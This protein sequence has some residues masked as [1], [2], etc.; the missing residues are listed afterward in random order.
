M[1][2]HTRKMLSVLMADIDL[3]RPTVRSMHNKGFIEDTATE[4]RN[5]KAVVV[6][7]INILL[8]EDE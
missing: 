8:E 7:L 3:S 2:K 6:N 1:L 4:L 5:T